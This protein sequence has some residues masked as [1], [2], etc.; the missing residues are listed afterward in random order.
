MSEHAHER[1][2]RYVVDWDGVSL[3]GRDGKPL[4]RGCARMGLVIGFGVYK[5]DDVDQALAAKD[6][7]IAELEAA[8]TA[9][10]GHYF[11]RAQTQLTDP[12]VTRRAHF[13]KIDGRFVNPACITYVGKTGG[14][15]CAVSLADERD[16]LFDGRTPEQM[17]AAIEAVMNGEV[18]S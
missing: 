9:E 15:N 5:A 14:S 7:R 10:G 4:P 3:P 13:I 11:D 8:C 2:T 16:T 1:L 12:P 17:V 6:K 18:P